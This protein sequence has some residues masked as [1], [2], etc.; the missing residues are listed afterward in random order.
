VRPSKASGRITLEGETA[1]TPDFLLGSKIRREATPVKPA[2]Q[3]AVRR[4]PV[5]T[6]TP[7]PESE[8]PR[9][10][11]S[12]GRLGPWSLLTRDPLGKRALA[13]CSHCQ[14]VREISIADGSVASCGCGAPRQ[15]GAET[16][17]STVAAA[18]RIVAISSI[19]SSPVR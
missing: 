18:E 4:P 12:L 2:S 11:F 15:T 17:A 5:R 8:P 13:K 1:R 10:P 14:T 3:T 19:N 16:F 6:P 7:R 9:D